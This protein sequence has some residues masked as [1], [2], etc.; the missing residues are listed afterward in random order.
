MSSSFIRRPFCASAGE[1][2]LEFWPA[3]YERLRKFL[4][5]LHLT[6]FN[7]PISQY[8]PSNPEVHIQRYPLSVKPV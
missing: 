5:K 1:Y 6:N 2:T 7:L 4:V 8:F 3:L